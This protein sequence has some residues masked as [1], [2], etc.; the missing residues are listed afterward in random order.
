MSTSSRTTLL[1]ALLHFRAPVRQLI[2]QLRQCQWDSPE[3]VELTPEM[4]ADVLG[5]HMRGELD[6]QQVEEWAN[7]IEGRDDVAFEAGHQ[8]LLRAALWELAN[9][10][11]AGALDTAHARELYDR[12]TRL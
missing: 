2:E 3:L 8:E 11:L 10:A 12:L 9:P 4:V 5:R 6:C 1:N 7:A